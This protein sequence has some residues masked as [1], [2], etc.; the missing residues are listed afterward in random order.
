VYRY[1][2]VADDGNGREAVHDPSTEPWGEMM[3]PTEFSF[4]EA[5]GR[6]RWIQPRAGFARLRTAVQGF[7]LLGTLLD[8]AP[9]EGGEQTFDWDGLDAS[10]T[11]QLAAHPARW[12]TLELISMPRN[13]ILVAG[14]AHAPA[15]T[16]GGAAQYPPLVATGDQAHL[17]LKKPRREA[18]VPRLSMELPSSEEVDAE[19]RPIVRGVVPVRVT[20]APEDAPSMTDALFEVAFYIDLTFFFEDEESTTPMTWL[21]D[22]SDLPSGPHLLTVNVFSYDGRIG[23][24]T[25]SVVV[26]SGQ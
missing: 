23:C 7:P 15:I 4:D 3:Q 10:G 5:T 17:E 11:V 24:L 21:W 20:I 26:G 8:W 18:L 9:L 6:L 12:I 2:L 14:G 13:T 1:I 16:A 19:G 22:T 25:R